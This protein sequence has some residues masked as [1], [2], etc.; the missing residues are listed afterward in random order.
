LFSEERFEEARK[1]FEEMVEHNPRSARGHLGLGF[2]WANRGAEDRSRQ[3][4]EEA[5]RYDDLMPEIYFLLAR[6]DEKNG[7][8][9]MAV[10]NYRRVILLEPEFA[11]AHF[12]LGN[13]YLK[14]QRHRDAR[15]EFNNTI[16]ILETDP[17][18]RSLKFSGGLSREA[19]IQF[20]EL[21][22]NQIA[23]VLPSPAGTRKGG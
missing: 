22:K 3:H 10:E 8:N 9:D 20:C 19:V 23:K 17:D 12:N 5:R 2:L 13:L 15:R 14:L 6:L 21:Q 16:A 18:N 11:M 1:I 7:L 4:V